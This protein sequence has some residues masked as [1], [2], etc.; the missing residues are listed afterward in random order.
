[1]NKT[2]RHLRHYT[3]PATHRQ[4]TYILTDEDGFKYY[5]PENKLLFFR[6]HGKT[7]FACAG[8][9]CWISLKCEPEFTYQSLHNIIGEWWREEND[10]DEQ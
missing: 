4:G 5:I 1:M 10:R 3:L 7:L 8:E 6:A 2:K 9:E